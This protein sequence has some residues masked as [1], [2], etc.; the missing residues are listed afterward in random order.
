MVLLTYRFNTELIETKSLNN[1]LSINQ[2]FD[3]NNFK[4]NKF[5]YFFKSI[6]HTNSF[7]IANFLYKNI[8]S[9]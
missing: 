6:N 4:W 9:E 8:P 5:Y 7:F 3:Y 2:Y 1:F